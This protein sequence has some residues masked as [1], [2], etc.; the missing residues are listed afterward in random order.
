MN[1][2]IA[3]AAAGSTAGPVGPDGPLGAS[4]GGSL[5]AGPAPGLPDGPPPVMTQMEPPV[6]LEVPGPGAPVP[7]VPG[8]DWLEPSLVTH[9]LSSGLQA[10]GSN[11][12]GSDRFTGSFRANA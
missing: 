10:G 5:S 8:V 9:W 6:P 3:R 4:V 1:P 12:F 2:P 7:G 11:P